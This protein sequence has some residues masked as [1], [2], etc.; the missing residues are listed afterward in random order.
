MKKQMTILLIILLPLN[1]FAQ[2]FKT[3]DQLKPGS[4]S[5]GINPVLYEK[6]AGVFLRGGLGLHENVILGVK[7]G[8]VSNE[9]YLGADIQW[10]AYQAD[11]YAVWLQTG[12]HD[13]NDIVVD[14]SGLLSF[15]LTRS[16]NVFTGF[17]VDLGF[18]KFNEHFTWVPVGIEVL[19]RR[20]TSFI[21]EM[22]IPMSHFA[23]SIFGGGISYYF[24]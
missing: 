7:Y 24:R 11:R 3:R 10:L 21:L 16:S 1:L 2:V 13:F 17:D 18:G 23:W 19:F 20:N 6:E 22:D 8:F 14:V 4:F 9:N 15:Q 12:A 5:I